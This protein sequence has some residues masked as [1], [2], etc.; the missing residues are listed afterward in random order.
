MEVKDTERLIE[1]ASGP[2]ADNAEL[3]L[4]SVALLQE[5]LAAHAAS[6]D[7]VAEAIGALED[8][9]R[10]PRRRYWRTGLY[11]AAF[12]A[13]LAAMVFSASQAYEAVR[14]IN[15][16]FGGVGVFG[17]GD[18]DVSLDSYAASLSSEQKLLMFGREGAINDADRWKPLWDSAPENPAFLAQYAAAYSKENEKFSPEILDAVERID[19]NNGW[20][21][22]SS[23]GWVMKDRAEVKSQTNQERKDNKTKV[24]EI[25]DKS[26]LEEA[27]R[28]IHQAAEKPEFSSYESAMFKQRIP[29]LPPRIDWVSQF[30]C[31]YYV[32]TQKCFSIHR[33]NIAKA[34]SAGAQECAANKDVEGFRRIVGDWQKLGT[35]MTRNGDTMIDML[36]ARMCIS[37]PLKNFSETSHSLGLEEEA[38]HFAKLDEAFV[39]EKEARKSSHSDYDFISLVTTRASMLAG[40]VIPVTSSQVKVPPPLTDADLRPSR[41]AEHAFFSRV[42][43]AVTW[44]LLVVF[45]GLVALCRFFKSPLVRTLSSRMADL[46]RLSDWLWIVL[47]GVLLPMFWYLSIIHLTPLSSREWSIKATGMV[48]PVGQFGALLLLIIILPWVIAG[49]RL[50]KRGGMFGLRGRFQWIGWFAAG[51]TAAAIPA[52]GAVMLMPQIPSYEFFLTLAAGFMGIPAIWLMVVFFLNLFGRS[53]QSLRRATLTGLMMAVWTI[54]IFAFAVWTPFLYALECRWMQ[55]DRLLEI[56]ADAPSLTRY[57][58]DVTQVLRAEILEI[59]DRKP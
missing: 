53:E 19:P 27:L 1:L 57:E 8:A 6:G 41:Y 50:G 5:S 34:L 25:K 10:Y 3:H 14:F 32:A 44:V 18:S 54:A 48:L 36:L 52:L 59:M 16:L 42:A 43:S 31:N 47:G 23:A 49:W 38:A 4:A 13:V 7:A 26:K 15:G 11:L 21:L 39:A 35:A 9:D 56:S 30:P 33:A 37:M 22:A 40:F 55:Q 29:L 45:I 46:L 12:A 51:L 17:R 24:W 58:Y 2:L 20:Y 28:L